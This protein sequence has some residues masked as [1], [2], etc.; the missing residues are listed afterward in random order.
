MFE[1]L[2]DRLESAFKVLKG[3]HRITELN[4]A[5][6]IKE[7]RRA[8]VAADVNYKIAKEFT[9]KVKEKALGRENILRNVN[10]GQL[11]VKIVFDELTALMG[12]QSVGIN[13]KGTPGVV[14][15]AGLQGSGK[16]TFCAKLA[17]Y[18]KEQRKMLPLLVACDVYRPAAIEQLNILG[19]S[20]QV[21][22]YREEG[23]MDPV[24]IARNALQY[25]RTHGQNVVI[26]DTAGRLAIDEAMM[27]EVA[28]I[29]RTIEPTETLFV[30][31]AMTGQDA[32]NTAQAFHER[33]Q[34]DGVVLTK[35]DG[36]TR[37]GAALSIKYTV[38][39]P[40]KFI[41]TGEKLET[42]DVF[43]PDRMARRILGMGDVLS[44]VE[45]AE[46]ELDEAEARRLEKR[47]QQNKFDFND[48]L[49][50]LQQIKR[51]GDLKSLL[52]MLPGM[53][54]ALRNIHIDERHLLHIEAMIKSMT[55][56]ERQNPD[57]LNLS[58]KKRIAR[59]SGVPLEK[60]NL[61]IKNFHDM[62]KLMQ[63]MTQHRGKMPPMP[64][65]PYPKGFRR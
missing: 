10:P 53:D 29:K 14:L 3:T 21:P 38:G 20:I 54:K 9:D 51:L 24:A 60:V 50:Q 6:S 61:F 58:R 41:S 47:L 23:N 27:A 5:E 17:R 34:Y 44:L 55:P 13:V 57:I 11:M 28:A 56:Q 31:D 64:R 46:M 2:S 35:L 37:G 36:D 26:L 4:V 32:V 43:H 62:R 33:I 49:S 39:K 65:M 22:V 8:L 1:S 18:L 15:V 30:V 63:Q 42:L 12:G 40:I 52:S 45:K 16:T 19:A 25:A 59:G 48:F 7:I